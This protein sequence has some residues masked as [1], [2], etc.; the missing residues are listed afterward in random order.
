MITSGE[1]KLEKNNLGVGETMY[2]RNKL[3]GQ[4]YSQYFTVT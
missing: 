3:Q 2:K 4:E 1:K